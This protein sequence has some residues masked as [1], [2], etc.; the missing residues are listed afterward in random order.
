MEVLCPL[1][2]HHELQEQEAHLGCIWDPLGFATVFTS[3]QTPVARWGPDVE[4]GAG[5]LFPPVSLPALCVCTCNASRMP[6]SAV[7]GWESR[8]PRLLL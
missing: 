6:P 1:S 4:V 3:G 2:T 8:S 7:P 5:Q